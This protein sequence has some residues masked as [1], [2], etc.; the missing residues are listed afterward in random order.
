MAP[1]NMEPKLRRILFGTVIAFL[2]YAGSVAFLV[3]FLP[4]HEVLRIVGSETRRPVSSSKSDKTTHDVF[5]I[6]AEDLETKNPRVFRN[7]DTRLGFPWYFKFNSPELQA[8]AQSIA[9]ERGTALLTYY[10]WRIKIFSILPNVTNIKRAAPDEETPIPWLYFGFAAAVIG[11]IA[12]LGF[13]IRGVWK[14]QR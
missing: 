14:R 3:Y 13:W 10:G 4:Y 5:Y 11:G 6:Y 9:D 2:V 7:D 8:V 12:L 1:K